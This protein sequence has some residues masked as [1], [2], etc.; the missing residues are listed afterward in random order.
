MSSRCGESQEEM[1]DEF[2][3]LVSARSEKDTYQELVLSLRQG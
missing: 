2:Y 1:V 3:M